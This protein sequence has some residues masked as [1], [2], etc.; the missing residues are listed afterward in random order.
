VHTGVPPGVYE[1]GSMI[2]SPGRGPASAHSA[3]P[4]LHRC[5]QVLAAGLWKFYRF[6]VAETDNYAV[7]DLLPNNLVE[8]G[9]PVLY[10]RHGLPPG[11]SFVDHDLKTHSYFWQPDEYFKSQQL[12][13]SRD[14]AAFRPGEWYAHAQPAHS[15]PCRPR[16]LHPLP[17]PAAYKPIAELIDPRSLNA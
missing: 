11:P 12:T 4:P 3:P 1:P 17:C 14:M 9:H 10:V 7:F 15:H 2:T 16:S 13:L 6:H 5:P 8:D